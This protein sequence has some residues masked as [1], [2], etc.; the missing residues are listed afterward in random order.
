MAKGS[1]SSRATRGGRSDS[2]MQSAG[3]RV[4]VG[5]LGKER[6]QAARDHPGWDRAGDLVA[7]GARSAGSP[8]PRPLVLRPA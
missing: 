1:G 2:I 7:G 5:I 6:S 8:A 3:P 4:Y